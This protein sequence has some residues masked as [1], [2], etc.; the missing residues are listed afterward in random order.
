MRWGW[1][2][3]YQSSAAIGKV[4]L[5][6]SGGQARLVLMRGVLKKLLLGTLSS[7][8]SLHCPQTRGGRRGRFLRKAAPPRYAF[9]F[10]RC[11]P[12]RL[13]L[14]ST[15]GDGGESSECSLL[16]DVRMILSA[17]GSLG[18]DP[19]GY[20]KQGV[21]GQAFQFYLRESW[22]RGVDAESLQ[23]G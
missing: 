4:R 15:A 2:L 7:G 11:E 19:Y 1:H 13:E 9:A 16:S 21:Q 18:G 14:A 23:R 8:T 20:G 10:P 5:F 12:E 6:S 3:M 22:Q 17:F